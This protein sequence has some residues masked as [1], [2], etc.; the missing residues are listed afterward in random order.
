MKGL[1]YKDLC[2]LRGQMKTY[3]VL[4]GFW[5]VLSVMNG[6]TAFFSGVMAMLGVL[7]VMTAVGYDERAQ[8]DA[9]ALVMP[10]TRTGVVLARY[11]FGFLSASVSCLAAGAVSFLF[12]E[13]SPSE[14]LLLLLAFWSVSL[15]LTAVLLPLVLR[16]GTEKA[17]YLMMAVVLLPIAAAWLL[18]K[19][20]VV[21]SEENFLSA[22][23]VL[24]VFAAAAQIASFFV[25]LA[26]YRKKEF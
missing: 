14:K 18:A 13:E 9:Q 26:I 17:R 16:F 6:G 10:V 1:L 7:T 22:L 4:I 19:T 21:L 8:W 2:N 25:S 24:P 3:L 5:L 12:G 20:G 15:L 11:V 23:P